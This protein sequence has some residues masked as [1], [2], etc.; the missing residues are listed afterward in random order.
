MLTTQIIRIYRGIVHINPM[1]ENKGF[2]P[3]P[4]KGRPT[5]LKPVV[6][7]KMCQL[8]G[9]GYSFREIGKLLNMDRHTFQ[10]RRRVD[11]GFYHCT[12]NAF[13]R[14]QKRRLAEHGVHR[15]HA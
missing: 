13:R 1:P 11:P 10:E 5:K 14:F 3:V 7:D 4:R 12:E 2:R 15:I 8:R 9:E 6:L